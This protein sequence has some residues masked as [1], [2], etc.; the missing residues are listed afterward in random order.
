MIDIEVNPT[1]PANSRIADLRLAPRNSN[2]NVEF[3]TEFELHAPMNP[4]LG[5]HRL[6][7]FVNNRG[8]KIGAGHFSYEADRNWLYARGWSYLWC[9]WNVDAIDSERK[10]N[11]QVPVATENGEPITARLYAE[12][13]NY[14]NNPIPSMPFTW[15]GSIPYETVSLDNSGARLTMQRYRGDDPVEV[16]RD[17]WSFARVEDGE[18]LPDAGHVAITGGFKPGWLY[19]LVYTG[20]NPKL[21][22]LGLA[23]IRDVVSFFR[24]E[25]TDSTGAPNSLAGLIEHT[26]A[27]GHSQSG[28]LLNHFVYQ[29]FNCDESHRPVFG[30][31]IA[32]CPG[33]GK[34]LFNSRFAQ[35]TRH[36]SHLEDNLYPID[37]F[38]FT[39]VEQIDPLTGRRGDAFKAARESGCLPKFFFVNSSTDYWTRAASLLHTDAEGTRDAPIDPAVRIYA[40]AG[41]THVDGRIGVISRALLT[42]LDQWVS[43]GIEPP[44]SQIPRIAD[45]T[46]ADLATWRGVFPAIPGVLMPES[47]YKPYRLDPGPR[48]E[49]EGIADYVPPKTGARYQAL[50]PQ[51]DRDGNELAGIKLPEIAVPLATFTGWTKRNPAFS[52][53]LGR[54]TGRIWPLPST[55]EARRKAGDPRLSIEERYP[56]GEAY[57][58]RVLDAVLELSRQRFLL[59]ED[60]TKMIKAAVAQSA[61]IGELR[62]LVEVTIHHG[63]DTGL[64]YARELEDAKL[65]WLQGGS[66]M[67]VVNN[68]NM[69]GYELMGSGQ[70]A[71]ALELF[72][73]NT[74]L[75]PDNGNVWDSM[76]ECY[77]ILKDYK[78]SL[79]YYQKSLELDP[80]NTNAVTMIERIKKVVED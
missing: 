16:H 10:L 9:G 69:K 4:Q 30:G 57:L 63:S 31:I 27:W 11:I 65:G 50:V 41:R 39:T 48:W 66:R 26:Y 3:T 29:N 80:E 8:N 76:A 6:I 60:V 14:Q 64:A 56:S 67:Q 71:S 1:N 68:I 47:Y 49:N 7:Y 34:G 42:A 46:L 18:L 77:F 17:Q 51:V 75:V 22:G 24:Y 43:K 58:L 62:D 36:G 25:T 37:F 15:G 73:L 72:R 53:S 70:L 21:T 40:I 78:Q 55:S 12:M 13:I 45:G 20:K 79:A 74:I 33:A 28:R 59:D 52:N 23:A 19:D 38:P 32:N 61:M 44:E 54:N 2:G 5:N 35:T